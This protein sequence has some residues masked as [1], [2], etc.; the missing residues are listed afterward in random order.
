MNTHI[1][2]KQNP[3]SWRTKLF[4]FFVVVISAGIAY[5]VQAHFETSKIIVKESK[6]QTVENNPLVQITAVSSPVQE[7]KEAEKINTPLSPP[8]IERDKNPATRLDEAKIYAQPQI[9]TGKYIDISLAHQNMVIFEDGK[10]LDAFLISSGKKG[11]NTPIGTFKIE[12]KSPRAWSKTYSLWMPDWMAFLPSG[13]MG[14]HE[15]PEWPGGYKEPATHLG[16]PISHGCIRLGVGPAKQVYDWAD[17]G[18]PV[19]IHK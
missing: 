13:E 4:I 7:N 16:T 9:L 6:Q 11:F 1:F 10:A 17:I 14:I 18:T 15:L 8:V 12:N 5:L 19:I 3:H 2:D